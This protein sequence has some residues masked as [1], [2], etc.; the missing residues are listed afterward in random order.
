VAPLYV[1]QILPPFVESL[2]MVPLGTSL[3]TTAK[4]VDCLELL[5]HSRKCKE[6][7]YGIALAN[8]AAY[9]LQCSPIYTKLPNLYQTQKP[10]ITQ[11]P[12]ITS[13]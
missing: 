7:P 9:S 8:H 6:A 13:L 1:G 3:T 12:P 2:K 11:K 5:C 10:H 4:Q